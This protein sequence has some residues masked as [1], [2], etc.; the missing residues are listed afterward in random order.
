M[1]VLLRGR[2][3]AVVFL[4]VQAQ[5]ERDGQAVI[6]Q[7]AG[8]DHVILW[9]EVSELCWRC[10]DTA[11]VSISSRSNSCFGT[12]VLFIFIVL[13]TGRLVE[14]HALQALDAGTEI[15]SYLRIFLR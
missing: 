3:G 12:F 14:A 13:R 11:M 5:L 6:G 10:S 2:G 8:I 9:Q 4:E 15:V 7:G 1:G